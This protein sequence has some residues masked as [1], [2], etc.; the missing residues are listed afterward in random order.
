MKRFLSIPNILTSARIVCAALMPFFAL[1]STG[2]Y[3]VYTFGGLTD[4]VDG[5]VARK[6]KLESE[7]GAKL[8][9]VADL[10]FYAVMLLKLLP[11]LIRLLPAWLWWSVGAVLAI[12][13]AAYVSAFCRYK[14]FASLHTWLNKATG[15][16]LFP[17]PYAVCTH[18]AVPYYTFITVVA[19]LASSEEFIMHLTAKKYRP[20]R[21]SLFDVRD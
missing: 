2:F 18:F 4:A 9:S 11:H 8:D 3:V 7:F 5:T 10:L 15:L 19:F 12:R 17:A 20:E 14:R 21:K 13:A 6:L 1:P 16:A